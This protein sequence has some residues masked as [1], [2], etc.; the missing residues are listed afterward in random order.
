MIH[1]LI[2]KYQV[3]KIIVLLFISLAILSCASKKDIYYFQDSENLNLENINHSFDPVIE[4]NDIL[5]ISL[6]SINNEL[7]RPFLKKDPQIQQTNNTNT[8]LDG[9]LVNIN[10]L[11]NFPVLGE[12]EV[13]GH[14][15]DYVKNILKNKLLNY[16]KDIVV[17]IR[18]INFKVTVLG[19]VN[20]PGVYTIEDERV[21][22]PEAIAMAG[23]LTVDGKRKTISVIREE[24][25]IQKVARIDIT[26]TEFYNSPFFYLKQNDLIY[27]EPS[28]KGVSK[29]GYISD[30]ASVLSIVTVLLSSIILITNIN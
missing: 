1:L 29:S 4:I 15:R 22:L 17:D 7:L 9:Y 25:G 27:A 26:N 10:G 12:I 2:N 16:I 20:K 14:T 8:G 13:A 3:N 28:G 23:D 6:S 5:H 11:I 18:I 30:I 19:E 24:N 21:T